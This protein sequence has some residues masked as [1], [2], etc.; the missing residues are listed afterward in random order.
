MEKKL[1][2]RSVITWKVCLWD[3]NDVCGEWCE[4][5]SYEMGL[6]GREDWEGSAWISHENTIQEDDEALFSDEMNCLARAVFKSKNRED[7]EKY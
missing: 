5:N 6:L 1:E 2:S 4:D 7:N 3:E